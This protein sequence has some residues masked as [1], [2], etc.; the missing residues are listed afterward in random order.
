VGIHGKDIEFP[1][2]YVYSTAK[3]GFHENIGIAFEMC[4]DPLK[5]R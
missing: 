5:L 3:C 1:A 4:G 2:K